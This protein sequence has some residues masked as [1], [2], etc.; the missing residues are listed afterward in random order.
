MTLAQDRLPLCRKLISD[1]GMAAK[2]L[3]MELMKIG[4]RLVPLSVGNSLK[5]PA[6]T[7]DCTLQTTAL[8][9]QTLLG[10]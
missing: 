4:Y 2:G 1:G 10:E 9:N 8:L 6:Q 7:I 5:I 3:P